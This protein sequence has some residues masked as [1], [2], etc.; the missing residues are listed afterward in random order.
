MDDSPTLTV[1]VMTVVFPLFLVVLACVWEYIQAI[2]NARKAG[3]PSM[4]VQAPQVLFLGFT[5][6]AYFVVDQYL[7]AKNF[8]ASERILLGIPFLILFA[9]YFLLWMYFTCVYYPNGRAVL[10]E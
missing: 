8:L 4:L 1:T 9:V 10:D 2:I 5:V 6:L 3:I 7:F